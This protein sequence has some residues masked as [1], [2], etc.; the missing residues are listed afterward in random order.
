MF[1][2]RKP[3]S[4]NQDFYLALKS[5]ADKAF[6]QLR[7]E[8][9]S[10]VAKLCQQYH[11]MAQFKEVIQE[12]LIQVLVNLDTE[13]YKFQQN[14]APATY[15][16]AIARFKVAEI[17]RKQGKLPAMTISMED[18]TILDIPDI[19][20]LIDWEQVDIVVQ[21]LRTKMAG[22]C[23]DLIWMRKAEKKSYQE[24][25]PVMPDYTHEVA[26]RNK[27]KKCWDRWM[28]LLKNDGFK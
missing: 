26:L 25:F 6:I 22:T 10:P 19:Q 28:E 4:T 2:K 24:I 7:Y 3:Y 20:E 17:Q 1:F 14:V 8:I 13:K 9:E 27:F 12:T 21:H 5:R 15:A 18:G 11:I 23:A 16:I